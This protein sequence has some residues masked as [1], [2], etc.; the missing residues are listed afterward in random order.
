MP[1]RSLYSYSCGIWRNTGHLKSDVKDGFPP[2]DEEGGWPLPPSP[3][4]PPFE[5]VLL[6]NSYQMVVL[7]PHKILIRSKT[8]LEIRAALTKTQILTC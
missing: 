7:T 2:R 3:M 4:V 8:R 6:Q 1:I 5:M